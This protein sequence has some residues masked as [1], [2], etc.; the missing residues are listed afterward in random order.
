VAPRTLSSHHR[1]VEL[2]GVVGLAKKVKSIACVQGPRGKS[3]KTK[4]FILNVSTCERK[5]RKK[6]GLKR[7]EGIKN[8]IFDDPRCSALEKLGRGK[9]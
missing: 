8:Y 1:A 6:K 5:K 7:P 2:T 3:E 9:E 4:K